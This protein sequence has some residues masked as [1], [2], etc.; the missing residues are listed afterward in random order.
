MYEFHETER[1]WMC[2]W[3]PPPPRSAE[4]VACS[5]LEPLGERSVLPASVCR[6]D[7]PLSE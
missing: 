3:G 5:D 6:D 4:P 1:G 2:C 7:E